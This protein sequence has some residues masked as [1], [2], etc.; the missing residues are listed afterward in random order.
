MTALVLDAQTG[1]SGDMTVAALLDLGA[2]REKLLSVLKTLPDQ[3]FEITISRVKKNALD[4]CDF[5]VTLKNGAPDNDH[6]MNYLF[7]QK[8]EHHHEEGHEH[9]T[10][11][12]HHH[13]HEHRHLH[14]IFAIIDQTIATSHAK[15]TAKKIFTI[16]AQAEAKA[17]GVAV[18]EVHFHEVGALDSIVD[19]LSVAVLIDDLNVDQ[20]IVTA[21]GEGYGEIRCQHGILPIPVPAVSHIAEAHALTFTHIDC[22]GEFVTPTGAAIVAALKTSDKLPQQ[23]KIIRSGLGAGKRAYER[24]SILRASLIE[25]SV[26]RIEPDAVVELSTNIDDC[27]GEMLGFTLE[28]LYRAGALEAWFSPVFM[29]KNRPAY[30][31]S[32]LCKPERQEAL[33]NIIFANTTSIGIRY[34][35]WQRRILSRKMMTVSTLYGEISVKACEV[36]DEKGVFHT[37]YYPEYDSVKA[38]SVEKHVDLATLY[39]LAQNAAENA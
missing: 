10:A 3:Q 22:R 12:E 27:T 4:A 30:I 38:L 7:G 5:K 35:T 11:H 18:E 24:A 26:G 28:K 2:S 8:H 13:H 21:L 23:Y 20:V 29:K 19:I 36:P 37:R 32:V 14:D 15:S 16:V 34:R 6:D 9:G 31:L 39:R 25:S 1:I 17:H 33:E